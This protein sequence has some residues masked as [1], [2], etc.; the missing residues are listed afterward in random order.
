MALG[1]MLLSLPLAAYAQQPDT[2]IRTETVSHQVT[3]MFGTVSESQFGVIN[4]RGRQMVAAITPAALPMSTDDQE[5]FLEIAAGGMMNLQASQLALTKS[6]DPA[7]R[8]LAKGEVEEQAALETKLREFAMIKTGRLP[9]SPDE[10]TQKLVAKLGSLS[11][12]DFDQYYTREV[13]I[14]G[15]ERLKKVME[16]TKDSARDPDLRALASA[17][18]PIINMHL[19]AA[20]TVK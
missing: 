8:I 11:G 6:T 13:A 4:E 10:K 1:G 19:Q 16:K 12:K 18:L 17:T 5:L 20:N 7:I 15:H 9:A 14:E 3:V 2:V